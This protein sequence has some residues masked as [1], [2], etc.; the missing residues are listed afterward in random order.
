M[1]ILELLAK[2]HPQVRFETW[3]PATSQ[4]LPVDDAKARITKVSLLR[5]R[6]HFWGRHHLLNQ[7]RG[8]RLDP[9]TRIVVCRASDH[10][11]AFAQGNGVFYVRSMGI[12]RGIARIA[13]VDGERSL[14][15]QP[16]A[17]GPS[18]QTIKV[19]ASHGHGDLVVEVPRDSRRPMFLGVHQLLDR[20][21][22]Y[23]LC[24]G[25]GVEVGP[26]P[27][28]QILPGPRV[29]VSYVEQSTPEDWT[30]LY[31]KDTKTPVDPSLWNRYVVGNADN[32]PVAPQSLD[33]IFSSHVIEHLANPLGHLKYWNSLLRKGG[34]VTAVIPDMEGCKD[35]V[36]TPSTAQEISEE[37]L[38]GDMEVRLHH[39]ERWT[40]HR[41]PD[42]QATE[43]L[44]TGRSIH[45]H[46]YTPSSMRSLLRDNCAA[47]G[48]KSSEVI[49][50]P[51][52]KDFFIVLKK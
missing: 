24:K 48:F 30:R 41:A 15:D 6:W 14:V 28:P 12:S 39:Y 32:I 51:N 35:F 33:F 50:T 4:W 21:V 26:G 16:V 10:W 45:V 17:F 37:F 40:A 29:D 20:S 19:P 13:W 25:R 44:A 22:L 23:A 1:N 7:M 49:A 36:F 27:K 34:T 5:R 11:P 52:H 43:V 9:G 8:V 18:I 38:A 31:G 3:S 46:F 47:M 42:K 2:Q